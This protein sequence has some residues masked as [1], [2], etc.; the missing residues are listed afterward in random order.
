MPKKQN[1][2]IFHFAARWSVEH[3]DDNWEALRIW[4][5]ANSDKY[6]YQAEYTESKD[7]ETG[8]VKGNP[9]YQI[10][11][12]T[13]DKKRVGQMITEV[14]ESGELPGVHIMPASTEGHTALSKYC[15]KE[16]SRVAGP[17]A[18]K[19]IYMGEDIWPEVKFPQWQKDL[20]QIL[21]RAPDFRTMHWV[22]D[23]VGNNGK[24]AF[25][26][27]LVYKEN[28]VGLGYGHSTDVLNLVS[29]LQGH[30]IYAWNLTRAKPANLSELDL[31]SAMESVK[32]GYFINLKY[33]TKMV[34]MS[35]PHVVVFANHFPKLNHISA[36]RWKLWEIRDGKLAFPEG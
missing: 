4:L 12:H 3:N 14:T 1:S 36:D 29:K 8:E 5:R 9:H 20:L 21:R 25:L 28:A 34:L 30:S 19:P 27:F 23:K 18:D 22:C 2:R 7:E 16:Q 10:Y 31:Y 17:W 24:T 33:E 35:R 15:M 26:K 13:K 6:I 11:F 32:D